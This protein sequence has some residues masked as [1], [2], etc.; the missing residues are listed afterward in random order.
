MT[1]KSDFTYSVLLPV[2]HKDKPEYLKIA[3]DS[4]LAQ[5][6]PPEEILIAVDG[7]INDDLR[8]VIEDYRKNYGKLFTVHYFETGRG[9]GSVLRDTLPLCR[10]EFIARMDADDYSEPARIERQAEM[11]RKFP[12]LKVV[13]C[14]VDEFED[15][16]TQTVAHVVMPE[17][18]KEISN[19]ARR[20]NPIRHPTTL[21][22]KS[23]IIAAGN[24][25]ALMR[26]EDYELWMRMIHNNTKSGDGLYNIQE[27]L[28][29]MRVNKT[30]Y[31]RRG[32]WLVILF[33]I[34][35]YADFLKCGYISFPDFL[36]NVF[37]RTFVSLMPGGFIEWFYKKFL[38]S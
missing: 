25:K 32:G 11:F 18:S 22:K 26:L 2:Y 1:E 5:T 30:F 36:V 13:G 10:N 27:P 8:G 3:V 6:I 14:N 15:N 16:I 31:R 29:H 4:M 23:E 9:L 7:P 12:E 28:V 24:Y 34:K 38:R 19:F 33:T 17:T 21:F 35:V 37:G 20:R